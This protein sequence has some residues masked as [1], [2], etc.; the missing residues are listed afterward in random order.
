MI[1]AV[2]ARKVM[3]NNLDTDPRYRELEKKYNVL[4]GKK[5]M[6][7]AGVIPSSGTTGIPAGHYTFK[8]D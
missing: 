1:N 6:R 8:R 2:A 7:E 3:L 4:I 5:S